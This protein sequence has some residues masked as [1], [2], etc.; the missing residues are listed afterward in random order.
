MQSDIEFN[1]F[2]DHQVPSNVN[3]KVSPVCTV[4][5]TVTKLGLG[6]TKERAT[7]TPRLGQMTE[8][9]VVNTIRTKIGA[10]MKESTVRT[11]GNKAFF[12]NMQ[13]MDLTL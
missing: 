4:S 7:V 10:P 3:W 1:Y 2:T 9:S 13:Q 8:D 12:H 11:G 6:Q 5:A